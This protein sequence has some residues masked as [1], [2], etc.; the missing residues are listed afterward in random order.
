MKLK[1]LLA[2]ILALCMVLSTMSFS[3]FAA[4]EPVIVSEEGLEVP[5]WDDTLPENYWSGEADT[6][7]YGD[8]T[9][10]EFTL[11]TAEQL[12]GLA[13]L[14]A[15]DNTFEGKII[16]LGANLD[17]AGHEW[18]VAS[19]DF[20]GTF[21]GQ[22]H[23][24]YNL[25]RTVNSGASGRIGLFGHVEN[26]TVK[27]L[28]IDGAEFY[29]YGPYGAVVAGSAWG[30]CV[31]ENI[32]L[33]NCRNEMYNTG[34][35]GIVG[36]AYYD[37]D[38]TFKNINID[39]TNVIGAYWGTYDISAG[40]LIGYY[41]ANSDNKS[42]I[43]VE[44]CYLAQVMNLYN[45]VCANYQWYAYRYSGMIIGYVQT[46]Q[47]INGRTVPVLD[48]LTCK[49][50]EVEYG[51]WANY[52]YCEW[53]K[54]G[55]GSYSTDYKFSREDGDDF[56]SHVHTAE[57][58]NHNVVI[59]FNQLYG[60]GQ[61]VYGTEKHE[62]VTIV[63]YAE[64]ARTV[65]ELFTTVS[66]FSG[67]SVELVSVGKF[68]TLQEAI[69][70]IASN[71]GEYVIKVLKNIEEDV[72]VTQYTNQKITI[73]GDETNKPVIGGTI[74]V[75]GRSNA[76]EGEA[77]TLK[78]LAFD[79]DAVTQDSIVYIPAGNARYARNITI[80]S[81][82][83][84]GTTD[85]AYKNVALLK[86]HTGG[87]S[88]FVITNTTVTGIHS[89][90][91]LKNVV[92]V[93]I[94][95][96]DVI[97]CKNG[98]HLG[99]SNNV[100]VTDTTVDTEGYGLR[101][102]N[103][104]NT[105]KMVIEL[106]GNDINAGEQAIYLREGSTAAN[107]T[108]NSG[109]YIGGEN[110]AAIE[111]LENASVEIH[112]GE[113]SSDVTDY[114]ADGLIISVN[115][116]GNYTPVAD[117]AGTST[118]LAVATEIKASL[119]PVDGN[120]N[121]F[122]VVLT[123]NEGAEIHRF[124]S[125]E[126][127]LLLIPDEADES[128]VYIKNVVGNADYAI[129]VID[130]KYNESGVWGFHLDVENEKVK[131]YTGAELKIATVE[132]AGYGDAKFYIAP[133]A[134]NKIEAIQSV[135]NNKVKK[136]IA[137]NTEDGILELDQT[138]NYVELKVPTK[139][140]TIEITF[141]NPIEDQV[142]AYQ[143]MTVTVDGNDIDT[144]TRKLG[145]DGDVEL[146]TSADGKIVQYVI[147]LNNKLTENNS[148]NI[149]VSGAGYRTADYRVTMTEDKTVYFWNDA[150]KG[151]AIPF[152]KDGVLKAKTSF[153]AGDIA[154]DNIIDKYD[155][156]AVVSYFGKYNLTNSDATY[157]YAKYD[158]NRDGNIDSEDIAYVLASFGY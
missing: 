110:F 19:K 93:T 143:D 50:V 66:T 59:G 128:P 23:T 96:I 125:A 9:A 6:D 12:A 33:K 102:G 140:L 1:K 114:L 123:A 141:Q 119:V 40:G 25:A 136:Y 107:L 120:P 105:G 154:E 76:E 113:Y 132:L 124:L 41:W 95:K 27:N 100:S 52:R 145:V 108:I 133:H 55:K 116:Y 56:D 26:G 42:K 65:A 82:D 101:A 72:T 36:L 115:G 54:N 86:E 122:D 97:D 57:E 18:V 69:D 111:S 62:G 28:T 137:D 63:N 117:D 121:K 48:E 87:G 135:D 144:I 39:N 79:A 51:E 13:E 64:D 68:G 129:D 112:S 10:E 138:I 14:I 147:K 5:A 29:G 142:A 85:N 146:E 35:A 139:D 8:G 91:Q 77:L 75:N 99:N 4:E 118:D 74:T 151:A 58:N 90:T 3:V 155:L 32:T 7:W 71:E 46:T 80:D 73:E 24:I 92:G 44:D 53:E 34:S 78:N 152:E 67:E 30:E 11:T 148:Y 127:N 88:N 61:G 31:F 16:K 84:V 45:D 47:E 22:Y 104:G 70:A 126:L 130:P 38:Y 37:S 89:L 131:E 158:L 109:K 153:L 134:N 21:D 103:N 15:G 157:K 83:V 94:E 60:G 149:T 156:A 20:S 98:I 49:N 106:S 81:C 2:S 150:V 43:L 17:M